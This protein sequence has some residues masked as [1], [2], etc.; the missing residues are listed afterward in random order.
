MSF[1]KF[2]N[3]S[4]ETFTL[5]RYFGEINLEGYKF[6]RLNTKFSSKNLI[7]D[8]ETFLILTFDR[9]QS[10][11]SFKTAVKIKLSAEDLAKLSQT[12][13]FSDIKINLSEKKSNYGSVE[14]IDVSVV[15]TRFCAEFHSASQTELA[16]DSFMLTDSSPYFLLQDIVKTSWQKNGELIKIKDYVVLKD[17]SFQ[18]DGRTCSQINNGNSENK[19]H[20]SG[21]AKTSF[22]FSEIYF[23]IDAGRSADSSMPLSSASH[24]VKN[25]KPFFKIL[26]IEENYSFNHDDESLKKSNSLLA[27]FSPLNFPFV[28][29]ADA[30]A[31]SDIWAQNQNISAKLHLKTRPF[32]FE[33]QSGAKQ[34]IISTNSGETKYYDTKNYFDSWNKITSLEFSPG[35]TEAAKRNVFAKANLKFNL[36]KNNFSPEYNFYSEES[37]K[38][39]AYITY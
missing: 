2:N 34:K 3:S 38:N 30:T 39:S 20:F 28:F 17:A 36:E 32:V 37:Y 5:T 29:S 26:N 14:K 35:K 31:D 10:D 15:P 24:T 13:K 25:A 12:Q 6:L 4:E 11:G 19:N 33:M 18:A 23:S 21:S 7:C 27:D 9:P 1:F 16:F 8:D 22:T